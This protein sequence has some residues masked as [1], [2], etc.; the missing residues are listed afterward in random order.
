MWKGCA[1]GL[2]GIDRYVTI[3]Y[4]DTIMEG[5]SMGLADLRDEY[6][7]S[8]YDL[9]EDSGVSRRQIA[10][11][12][13]GMCQRIREDTLRKLARS[14]DIDARALK[15]IIEGSRNDRKT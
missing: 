1:Y 3:P 7:M 2:Q 5:A 4:Y 11:I 13:A 12:E 14:F 8:Q 10:R 6:G 15:I 9:A